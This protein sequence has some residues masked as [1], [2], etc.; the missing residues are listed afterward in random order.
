L[1]QQTSQTVAL[2]L[3]YTYT[4]TYTY[5]ATAMLRGKAGVVGHYVN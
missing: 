2:G 1:N 5:H 3:T 4:Y